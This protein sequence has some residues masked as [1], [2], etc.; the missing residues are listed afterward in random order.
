MHFAYKMDLHLNDAHVES[1]KETKEAN[2][3][4]TM[5]LHINCKG[6]H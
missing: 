5:L 3:I 2:W 1:R 4:E 6:L